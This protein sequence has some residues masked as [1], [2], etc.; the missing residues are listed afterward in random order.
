[1]RQQSLLLVPMVGTTQVSV[2]MKLGG[3]LAY[4]LLFTTGENFG[5][6]QMFVIYQ[7]KWL[8]PLKTGLNAT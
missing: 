5:M 2:P 3:G 4:L 6:R 8:P 1:M 7:S